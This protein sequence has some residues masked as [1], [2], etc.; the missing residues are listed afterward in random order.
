MVDA[1]Q[2]YFQPAIHRLTMEMMKK[3]NTVI[4]QVYILNGAFVKFKLTTVSTTYRLHSM[5]I[6][7]LDG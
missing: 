4:W 7:Q 1:E 2:T 5:F 6:V 3:Y